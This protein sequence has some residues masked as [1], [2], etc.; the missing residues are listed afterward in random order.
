MN[1]FLEA[2]TLNPSPVY[3]RGT[4]QMADFLPSAILTGEGLGVRGMTHAT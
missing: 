4:F 1:N 3:G 2:L